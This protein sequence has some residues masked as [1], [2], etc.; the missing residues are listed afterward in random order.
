VTPTD[1]RVKT[2]REYPPPA[3]LAGVVACLWRREPWQ[4]PEDDLGVLPDGMAD[5]I[6]G[7]PGAVIVIGPQTRSRVRPCAPQTSVVGARF[8]PGFGPPLLGLPAHVLADAHVRL[9]AI[10]EPAA[11]ALRRDLGSIDGPDYPLTQL[12]DA[13]TRWIHSSA[14]RIADGDVQRALVLLGGRNVRVHQIARDLSLSERQLERRFR[15]AIGYGPTKLQRVLRF[16]SLLA[17]L[18]SASAPDNLARIATMVGYA[19][20]SHLTREAQA[21]SGF[22]P[23]HLKQTLAALRREGAAG[24][25]KTSSHAWLG[26]FRRDAQ[27]TRAIW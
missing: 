23:L 11:A 9:D 22:T 26:R 5:V 12:A 16:Q 24:I 2:Y 17:A 4:P 20:Q 8:L 7:G 1:A 14:R 21:L 19:D 27:T 15:D 18:Q 13:I 10:D 25:F 3:A 6:W